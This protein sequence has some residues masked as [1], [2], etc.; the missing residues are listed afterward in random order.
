[1]C[2]LENNEFILDMA[3]DTV[4][5]FILRMSTDARSSLK[6]SVRRCHRPLADSVGG[7]CTLPPINIGQHS[8]GIRKNTTG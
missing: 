1:M 4:L 6:R 7:H 2:I 8:D 5:K 3:L